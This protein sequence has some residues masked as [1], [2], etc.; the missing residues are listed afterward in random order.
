[1]VSVCLPSHDYRAIVFYLER[2]QRYGVL[3]NADLFSGPLVHAQKM[4]GDK[5]KEVKWKGLCVND[6]WQQMKGIMMEKR[7]TYVE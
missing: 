4:V 3:K 6:H 5:V 1:M 7:R 2:F